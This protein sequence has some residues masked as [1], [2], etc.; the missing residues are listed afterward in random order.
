M[1][2]NVFKDDNWHRIKNGVISRRDIMH[3]DGVKDKRLID[4][5]ILHASEPCRF[6]MMNYAAEKYG[7]IEL[8][9]PCINIDDPE[10]TSFWE[11]AVLSEQVERVEDRETLSKALY[12]SDHD[13]AVFA[14][15][16]LTGY[17]FK[18]SECDAYSY[19]TFSCDVLPGTTP[20]GITTICQILIEERG[21]LENI[22]KECLRQFDL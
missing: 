4:Y 7:M 19:R 15:C 13:V 18:P 22:A 14:F 3:L 20:E 5:L 6:S 1:G 12:S 9:D 11:Y 8:P 21:A 10:D 2:V 17:R 16:R